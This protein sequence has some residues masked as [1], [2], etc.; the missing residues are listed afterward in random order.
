M[1]TEPSPN[2]NIVASPSTWPVKQ[3]YVLSGFFLLL[4]LAIGYFFFGTK[5]PGTLQSTTTSA[6]NSSNR[7]G[8]PRNHPPLTPDQMK[9][10]AAVQTSALLEKLK[11]DPNNAS[12]LIQVATIYKASHQCEEA[13]VF[14]NR[15]LKLD[16]KNLPARAELS[17]CLYSTGDVDGAI[18]QLNQSLKYN[19]TDPTSLFNLGVIKWKGKNDTAGAI[20]AW[21]ELLKTNPN[22]DRKPI[23][24]HMIAEVQ[25]ESNTAK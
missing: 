2:P 1:P 25:A 24:E 20:T 11:S 23:V 17:S 15:A 8:L 5:S 6:E 9:Q 18:A 21:Q 13:S 4:G 19:P 3:V 14:Y 12:L 10:M 16:P 7:D 22:L